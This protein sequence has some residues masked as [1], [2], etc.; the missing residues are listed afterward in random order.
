MVDLGLDWW[1][2]TSLFILAEVDTALRAL[3][4][5]GKWQSF[6]RIVCDSCGLAYEW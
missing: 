2:L 1:A 5:G 6:G 3:S 4:V